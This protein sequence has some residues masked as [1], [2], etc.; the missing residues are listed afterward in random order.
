VL[1]S[2]LGQIDSKGTAET[3]ETTDD[4]VSTIIS[5]VQSLGGSTNLQMVA[6]SVSQEP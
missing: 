4:K 1:D 6:N 5:E 3:S 2:Y